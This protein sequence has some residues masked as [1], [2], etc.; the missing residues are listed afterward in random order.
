MAGNVPK[1]RCC[2]CWAT[3][4]DARGQIKRAKTSKPT[5]V[6]SARPT[7][8][9]Q[10]PAWIQRTRARFSILRWLHFAGPKTVTRAA[11]RKVYSKGAQA[12]QNFRSWRATMRGD[13]PYCTTSASNKPPL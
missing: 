6:K 5:S 3:T 13:T 10:A 4:F 7:E 8:T 2:A 1:S 12:V 11:Q 9:S